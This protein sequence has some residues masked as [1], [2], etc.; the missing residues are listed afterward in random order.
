M[1]T[2]ITYIQPEKLMVGGK[3]ITIV[4]GVIKDKSDLT[5]RELN[6]LNAFLSD[7]RDEDEFTTVVY[8]I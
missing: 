2:S 5:P 8:P 4:A 6:D 3:L 1:E 7:M